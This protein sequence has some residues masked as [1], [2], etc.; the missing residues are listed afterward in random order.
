MSSKS[1]LNRSSVP[2]QERSYTWLHATVYSPPHHLLLENFCVI[3]CLPTKRPRAL[4]RSDTEIN[5]S[6]NNTGSDAIHYLLIKK[7][8]IL[9]SLQKITLLTLFS[10]KVGPLEVPWESAEQQRPGRSKGQ[11]SS[12]KTPHS[13]SFPPG[14]QGNRDWRILHVPSKQPELTLESF[15]FVLKLFSWTHARAGTLFSCWSWAS[16]GRVQ[17]DPC[18]TNSLSSAAVPYCNIFFNI[19]SNFKRISI[20]GSGLFI[21]QWIKIIFATVSTK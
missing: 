17:D 4:Q 11:G 12:S 7:T 9:Q 13:L 8:Q 15:G 6:W 3:L 14:P 10:S 21:L 16:P 2:P 20:L 18:G 1:L 19:Y 5:K